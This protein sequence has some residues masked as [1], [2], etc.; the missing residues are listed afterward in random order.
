MKLVNYAILIGTGVIIG[1]VLVLSC[2]DNSPRKADAAVDAACNCPPAEV[3][4]SGRIVETSEQF[5]IPANSAHQKNGSR[6]CASGPVDGI[7]LNGGC[8]ANIPL[9]GNI[10]LEQSAPEGLGWMCS[11]SN[12]SN[13]DVPVHVIMRCLM[14]AK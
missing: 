3:P 13:V 9:N 4:L 1:I 7:V 12:P 5:V 14:P 2:G 11:W 8:T 6:V 10:I